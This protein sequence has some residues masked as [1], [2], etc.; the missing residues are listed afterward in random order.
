MPFLTIFNMINCSNV[1]MLPETYLKKG[2][3]IT[4]YGDPETEVVRNLE[5]MEKADKDGV[6]V[7]EKSTSTRKII[8]KYLQVFHQRED[9]LLGESWCNELVLFV[10]GYIVN[11]GAMSFS[12]S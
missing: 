2:I 7:I 6:N 5:N 10:K 9:W 4:V 11:S 8:K 12:Y 3:R 1:K